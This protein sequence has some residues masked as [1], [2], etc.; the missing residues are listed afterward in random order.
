MCISRDALHRFLLSVVFSNNRKAVDSSTS[1]MACVGTATTKT[2]AHKRPI[3]NPTRYHRRRPASV[4]LLMLIPRERQ[5]QTDRLI[6]S[7]GGDSLPIVSLHSRVRSNPHGADNKLIR[8]KKI[9]PFHR[10]LCKGKLTWTAF[11]SNHLVN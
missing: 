5:R 10:H 6:A 9:Q 11:P 3:N 8:Q 1:R 7:E 4:S 2:V